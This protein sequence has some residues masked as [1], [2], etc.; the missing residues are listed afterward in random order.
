MRTED[1]LG[2]SLAAVTYA[3]ILARLPDELE[4]KARLGGLA[5][6]DA[7]MVGDPT[8]LEEGELWLLTLTFLDGAVVSIGKFDHPGWAIREAARLLGLQ[9]LENGHRLARFHRDD[10]KCENRC[11]STVG[12]DERG[13]K[14]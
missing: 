8:F 12:Y 1:W 9:Y 13:F 3:R 7:E 11:P 10:P 6:I 14:L 5:L 2:D 4:A